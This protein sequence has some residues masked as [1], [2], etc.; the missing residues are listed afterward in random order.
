MNLEAL[1][2][3]DLI[4]YK[5]DSY[6]VGKDVITYPGIAAGKAYLFVPGP[7]G[8]PAYTLVKRQLTQEVGRGQLLHLAREQRAWYFVQTEFI[9]EFLGS[10]SSAFSGSGFGY[11]IEIDLPAFN[12]DT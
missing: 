7:S 6:T 10:S 9:E 12:E 2:I 5:G 3:D 1:P 8:A 11:C 4:V